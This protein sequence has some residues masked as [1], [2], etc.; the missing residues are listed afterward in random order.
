[1]TENSFLLG[2]VLGEMHGNHPGAWR[3]P[4][5]DPGAYTD[6]TTFVRAAQTA[7]RGG[8][9]Y[10]FFPDRVFI[11]GDL[12]SR[13]P[14][15]TM[16]PTLTLAAIAPATRRIGLVTTVST[17]F[18]EPYTL[19]RQVRALDVMSHG[20]AGW[21]A[22]PSYEPEAF[23]NYGLPVPPREEKYERF[24][25]V[26]Q[27]TQALWGS[28]GRAAGTPDKTT[29]RF[30]DTAHIRPI[31]MQGRYVAS[32]GPLQ[33]PPSEQGQPVIFMP[34]ASGLGVQAAAKYA[35]GIIAGPSSIQQG[36]AQRDMMRALA[37]EAGRDA[38]EVK[39]LAFA[40]VTVGATL[41][42]AA[43]RR[44]GLEEAAGLE[45]RLAQL[46]AVLGLRL[47]PADRDKPLTNAQVA[48]LRPHPGAPQAVRALELARQGR[49]PHEIL[50]HGVLDQSPSLLGTAEQIADMLQ[51]W[52]QAG[53]ADGFSVIIDDLH[54]GMD[55]FV[56]QV[57][58][59]LRQ[60]GLRP[61]D[62]KGA[63][64]R[65]H[66]GLPEQLGPDPRLAARREA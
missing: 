60:R 21:Q 55:A 7:E 59:V 35:N 50:G 45:E 52:V 43:Q 1:M 27:I 38:D 33:I 62:Y 32:R 4:S 44:M 9:D 26:I 41:Q 34:F 13:P 61:D 39:F 65:D 40:F 5:A 37:V 19:A 25:E 64:L 47:D 51:E 17:S 18:V 56:D 12:E 10:L 58:P 36:K 49:T 23:A 29:G 28:W 6:V 48:A 8:L 2:A 15:V 63:T 22:I 42:E 46:S 30:A 14:I 11:W 20:R 54:D 66:L 16:E 31:N 53:A 57:V 3:M 24:D